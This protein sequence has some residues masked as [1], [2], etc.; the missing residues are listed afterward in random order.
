[1]KLHLFNPGYESGILS[2][3]IYYTPPKNVQR[4][5]QE[6]ASLPLWYADPEDYIWVGDL[7]KTASI[8]EL[9]DDIQQLPALLNRQTWYSDVIDLPPL[10]AAPWGLSQQSIFFFDSLKSETGN[11]LFVPQWKDAYKQLTGRQT[12]ATCLDKIRQNTYIILPETPCFLHSVEE[13]EFFIKKH[14][15]PFV[16][17]M[18]YSS[19]GRGLLRIDGNYLP[20]KEKEWLTGALRKQ[21]V[22]SIEPRLRKEIDFALEFYLDKNGKAE[23]KGISLFETEEWKTYSGNKLDK[24]ENLEAIITRYIGNEVFNEV[25][26]VVK[27][28]IEEVFGKEYTGYLGVD[29]MLYC[30]E[31]KTYHIHPCVEINMRYTMGMVAIRIFE[32]FIDPET[33]GL[34]QVIYQ[35]KCYLLHT[36]MQKKHPPIWS[37]GKL[38]KGYLPL[39]P[40][41]PDNHYWAYIFIE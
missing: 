24:Q 15:P 28:T 18:P 38:K 27:Q 30:S 19:S 29:M 33:N 39:C 6:L 31:E 10:E 5:R 16:L 22:I 17:K 9:P 32:R 21:E 13:V 4:M 11:E 20:E 7:D 2:G 35:P 12:A 23:Y 34:F 1:M 8:R 41:Y 40:V 37:D 3:N 25:K 26:K 14:T 36:E